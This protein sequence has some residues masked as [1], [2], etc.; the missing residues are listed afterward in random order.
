MNEIKGRKKT[1][2]PVKNEKE[3]KNS[4]RIVSASFFRYIEISSMWIF[5]FSLKKQKKKREKKKK[6]NKTKKMKERI[7]EDV[8]QLT[9]R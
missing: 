4:S 3:S 2:A 6:E 5:L 7:K 8:I 1:K 9:D